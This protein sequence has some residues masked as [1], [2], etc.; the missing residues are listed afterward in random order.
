MHV[1][2]S[3]AANVEHLTVLAPRTGDLTSVPENMDIVTVPQRPCGIPHRFGGRW[4]FNLGV[5]QLCRDRRIDAV[6]VHMAKDWTYIL[7]PTFRLLGIPVVL[8]YA[9]GTVSLRLRAAVRCADRVITSTPEGCRI[10]DERIRIIGQA[11]DTERF[12]PPELRRLQTALYVG[13]ISRRK[14]VDLIYDAAVELR[15]L[16]PEDDA[17]EFVLAGGP[18]GMEDLEYDHDLRNRLWRDRMDSRVR[19]LGYVPF[20]RIPDLYQDAF[21]HINVSDTGSMD[22][23]VMEALA[24]GCPVLTSNRAFRDTLRSYPEFIIRDV[25]PAA[26]AEQILEIYRRR[27]DYDPSAL[28]ALVLDRHSLDTYA[29]RVLEVI[30]EVSGS[31]HHP[32]VFRRHVQ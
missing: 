10:D 22:K 17:P 26:I 25:R 21:V 18:R 29:S 32:S 14:R 23:S 27:R 4:A 16:L 9:H 7:H 28:R 3:L 19:M 13:R 12:S 11:I 24:A 31:R 2:R 5:Y 8:W 15:R 30:S 1:A 6:F 20:E